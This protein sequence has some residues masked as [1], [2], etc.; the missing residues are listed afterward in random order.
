[1]SFKSIARDFEI[2]EGDEIIE[3]M[4]VDRREG[5]YQIDLHIL[6]WWQWIELKLIGIKMKLFY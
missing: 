2:R 5:D 4:N 3:I 6:T 1:M